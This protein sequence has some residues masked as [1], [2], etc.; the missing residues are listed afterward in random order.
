MVFH[1]VPFCRPQLGPMSIVCGVEGPAE[2]ADVPFRFRVMFYAL[3]ILVAECCWCWLQVCSVFFQVS[4]E[5][6]FCDFM[7][8]VTELGQL[9]FTSTLCFSMSSLATVSADYFIGTVFYDMSC[10]KASIASS[11]GAWFYRALVAGV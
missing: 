3:F 6:S 11:V 9:F 1:G 10:A 5:S 2:F 8:V 4:S 7:T